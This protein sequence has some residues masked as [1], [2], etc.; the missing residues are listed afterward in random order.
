MKTKYFKDEQDFLND[1]SMEDY[2][3]PSIATDIIIFTVKKDKYNV[4]NLQ[5]LLIKR[6]DHPFKDH[7]ALPGGF[8]GLSA[9]IKDAVIL[10]CERPAPAIANISPL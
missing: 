8:M 4:D 9:T 5:L 1:Y 10:L 6:K 3:R 2:D 7:W